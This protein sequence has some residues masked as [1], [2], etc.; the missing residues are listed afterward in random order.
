VSRQIS[1][2]IVLF[3]ASLNYVSI[4][5]RALEEAEERVEIWASVL[6][7]ASLKALS[8]RIRGILAH[9]GQFRRPAYGGVKYG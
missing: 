5:T 3:L 1:L 6:R 4:L 7:T 9:E 8:A 2:Q